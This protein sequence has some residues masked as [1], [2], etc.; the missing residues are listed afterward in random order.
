MQDYSG[1]F[2]PFPVLSDTHTSF[3]PIYLFMALSIV[4]RQQTLCM[5]F[6]I[7]FVLTVIKMFMGIFKTDQ[8]GE[9]QVALFGIIFLFI[10]FMC[11]HLSRDRIYVTGDLI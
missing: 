5:Y 8:I 2:V 10:F 3:L 1:M 9:I 11:R 6:T 4:H 7:N